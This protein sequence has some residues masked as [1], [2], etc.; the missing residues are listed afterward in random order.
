MILNEDFF[1]DIE[2][3]D[4]DL[5][6]DE[7]KTP[8][9]L[10]EHKISESEMVLIIR[11]IY[12]DK[13]QDGRFNIW[14]R[15]ER[16]MKRLEYMLNIY[17]INISEPFITYRP[18]FFY[19]LRDKKIPDN[20]TL[21][22]H[23]GCNLYFPENKLREYGPDKTIEEEYLE[24]FV[25]LDKNVPVFKR[26]MSACNFAIS[27]DKCIWKDVTN[28]KDDCFSWYKLYHIDDVDSSVIKS[29][30]GYNSYINDD[31]YW[32]YKSV[33]NIVPEEVAE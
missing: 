33:L 17:N 16:M 25:F 28:P 26:A 10:I 6:N 7:P 12:R 13:F 4:E 3:K 21:I 18:N 27:L 9:E 19:I 31:G 14:S 29:Y 32:I 24:L 30:F 11:I 22:Q 23:K 1:N 20:Y 5:T 15:I 2:I 8:R